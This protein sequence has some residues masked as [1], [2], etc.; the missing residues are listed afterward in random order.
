[1]TFVQAQLDGA[2]VVDG[3]KELLHGLVVARLRRTDEVVVGDVEDLPR[4]AERRAGLIHELLRGKTLRLR[5]PHDVQA[6]LVDPGQKDDIVVPESPPSCQ[7]VTRD[8]RVGVTDVRH[9]VRIIDRSRHVEWAWHR[10]L[11]YRRLRYPPAD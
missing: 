5:G 4:L 11:R 9:V 7:H 6:V 1:E 2:V 3:L 8:R 10:R